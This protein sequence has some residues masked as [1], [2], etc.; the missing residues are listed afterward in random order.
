MGGRRTGQ[1][2]HIS[3]YPAVTR[4]NLPV[5]R[6]YYHVHQL[7]QNGFIEVAETR[8]AGGTVEKIYFVTARQFIV[9]RQ[10]FSGQPDQALEQADILV[11][12]TLTQASKAIRKSVESGAIDLTHPAPHP[13][14]LQIRRGL[15]RITTAQAVE[16]QQKLNAL[17]DEFTRLQSTTEDEQGEYFLA[18]AFFPVSLA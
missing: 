15:G 7:E 11:D 3:L 18:I 8:P 12:F 13:R 14:A 16:F 17:I 9:D 10:E 6:L 1:R 5:T 4:L 2:R